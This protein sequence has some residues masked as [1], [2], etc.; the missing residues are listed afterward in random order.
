MDRRVVWKI[1]VAATVYLA[2]VGGFYFGSLR[3]LDH[4]TAT[5]EKKL[6]QDEDIFVNLSAR[7]A[8]TSDVRELR[9][10]ADEC[11]SGFQRRLLG[12]DSNQA[13]LG[14]INALCRECGVALTG[15]T[16]EKE[17]EDVGNLRRV[18]WNVALVG[19]YHAIGAFLSRMENARYFLCAEDMLLAP[20]KDSA[21]VEARFTLRGYASK[22]AS[23][24]GDVNGT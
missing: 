23:N 20:A 19:S 10:K 17:T 18:S 16:P 24:R 7:A 6:A 1:A 13:V 11:L 21:G 8:E 5:L 4:K 3:P 15:L 22:P 14:E 2:V 9:T 12:A